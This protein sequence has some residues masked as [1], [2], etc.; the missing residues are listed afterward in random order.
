MNILGLESRQEIGE[1]WTILNER[2]WSGLQSIVVGGGLR[3]LNFFYK[4]IPVWKDLKIKD[5]FLFLAKIVV[6]TP[7]TAIFC[8]QIYI[9]GQNF[10]VLQMT[11]N[12]AYIWSIEF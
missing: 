2:G 6:L 10:K 5:N 1:N 11:S 7:H 3:P 12:L 8:G 9:I 4:W